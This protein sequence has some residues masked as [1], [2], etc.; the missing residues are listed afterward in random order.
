MRRFDVTSKG[1]TVFGCDTLCH[2]NLHWFDY[3]PRAY[4]KEGGFGNHPK[5]RCFS[6]WSLYVSGYEKDLHHYLL[7]YFLLTYVAGRFFT[8]HP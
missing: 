7:H 6:S 5:K 8:F 2:G 4:C 3:G 1:G